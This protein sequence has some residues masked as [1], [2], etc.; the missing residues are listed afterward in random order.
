L[1]AKIA[2]KI[3]KIFFS[4]FGI[5]LLRLLGHDILLWI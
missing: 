2:D 3:K 4:A 1:R 5:L